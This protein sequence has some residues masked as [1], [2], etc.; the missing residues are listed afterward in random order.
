VARDAGNGEE[1]WS[2]DAS[3]AAVLERLRNSRHIGSVVAFLYSDLARNF[4]AAIAGQPAV[5]LRLLQAIDA[6]TP[7]ALIT[8]VRPL[9]IPDKVLARMTPMRQALATSTPF[10]PRTLVRVGARNRGL[11]ALDLATY[12]PAAVAAARRS[13]G[14]NAL[15]FRPRVAPLIEILTAGHALLTTLRAAGLSA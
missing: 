1:V 9:P 4:F 5:L 10:G 12:H 2:T 14:D 3:I 13:P 6:P 8:V 7:N 11:D 15:E